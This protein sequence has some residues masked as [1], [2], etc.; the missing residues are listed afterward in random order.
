MN[1]L[2]Q[3]TKCL[4][5]HILSFIK[6]LVSSRPIA[7]RGKTI[8]SGEKKIILLIFK[9]FKTENS[10]SNETVVITLTFKVPRIVKH[11]VKSLSKI[12]PDRKIEFNKLDELNLGV[13][14]RMIHHFYVRCE[15][16]L[17]SISLRPKFHQTA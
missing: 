3:N 8:G 6:S 14:R 10:S 16:L 11:E 13:I 17:I 1:G 2:Y 15:V 5:W 4:Q 12:Q 7:V 9:H